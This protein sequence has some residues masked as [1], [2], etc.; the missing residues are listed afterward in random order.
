MTS[1]FT[2]RC[3]SV[4]SSG[5]LVDQQHDQ[6]DF[7]MIGGD[8]IGDGLQHHRFAGAR[9]RDDQAALAFADGAEHVEHAPGEI[10]LGRFQANA[11]LRVE[12]RQVVEEDL[13]ARD[14]RDLRS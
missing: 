6:R 9:R 8:G 13:V 3:M 4:T 10:F 14:F 12:R 7:R 2:V 1:P 5:P 11:L